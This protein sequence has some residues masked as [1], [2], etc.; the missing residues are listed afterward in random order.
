MSLRV[1]P[2]KTQIVSHLRECN[3]CSAEKLCKKVAFSLRK[4]T[5]LFRKMGT[6]IFFLEQPL[7]IRKIRVPLCS[8]VRNL[9]VEQSA[10]SQ[11]PNNTDYQAFTRIVPRGTFCAMLHKMRNKRLFYPLLRPFILHTL[12]VEQCSTNVPRNPVLCST[13]IINRLT[14]SDCA[15]KFRGTLCSTPLFSMFHGMFHGTIYLI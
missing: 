12:F 8:K 14:K 2:A 13:M 11:F 1:K 10:H 3:I 4:P 15:T 9:F 5:G 7:V 6:R